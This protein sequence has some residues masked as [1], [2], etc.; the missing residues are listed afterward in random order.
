MTSIP[1]LLYREAGYE[2]N[3]RLHELLWRQTASWKHLSETLEET[4][5]AARAQ[6]WESG[7]CGEDG[8]GREVAESDAGSNRPW[9]SG[10]ETGDSQVG[11]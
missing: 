1:P 3:G 9:Y 7:K 10:T 4:L 8:V 11:E 6:R 5:E 2:G